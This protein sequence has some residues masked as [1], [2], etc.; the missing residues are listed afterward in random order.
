MQASVK[1]E[2]IYSF[3]RTFARCQFIIFRGST[4]DHKT[5][6]LSKV[7]LLFER[8]GKNHVDFSSGLK[9]ADTVNVFID[10]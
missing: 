1:I 9:H 8:Q 5:F 6:I 7:Q 3:E 10:D 4:I 2:A